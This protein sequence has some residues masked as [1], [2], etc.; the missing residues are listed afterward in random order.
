MTGHLTRG[1]FN[2]CIAAAISL[3]ILTCAVIFGV[4]RWLVA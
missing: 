3:L 4:A 2:R 1:R